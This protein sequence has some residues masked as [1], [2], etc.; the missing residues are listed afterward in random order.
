MERRSKCSA[1]RLLAVRLALPL[2]LCATFPLATPQLSSSEWLTRTL[3]GHP[4]A[5]EMRDGPGA[6]A[7]F[8]RP[9]SLVVQDSLV[10]IADAGGNAVRR[11]DLNTNLVTT[12]AGSAP[13]GFLDAPGAAARFNLPAAVALASDGGT[14]FIVDCNNHAVRTVHLPTGNVTTLVGSGE[15]FV[16]GGAG[17]A[18]FSFPRSIAV[19]QSGTTAYLS[20]TG[21]HAIREITL[22]QVVTAAGSVSWRVGTVRTLTGGN[23]PGFLD[24]AVGGGV[25]FGAARFESPQALTTHG[26]VNLIVADTGNAKVRVIDVVNR[27]VGT[28]DVLP[29]GAAPLGVSAAANGARLVVSTNSSLIVDVALVLVPLPP[30]DARQELWGVASWRVLV[31]SVGEAGFR[32]GNASFAR[33]SASSGI[34]L[35]AS[36]SALLADAGNRAVRVIEEVAS[37]AFQSPECHAGG[38]GCQSLGNCSC[39]SFFAAKCEDGCCPCPR[40]SYCGC[41]SACSG[42]PVPCPSGKTSPPEP[43]SRI[44]KPE[45]VNREP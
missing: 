34:A 15:G 30:G 42:I 33:L 4:D 19:S 37:A 31:G 43:E 18:S 5:V 16:N 29:S 22:V 39:G 1:A 6:T 32:D 12:V 28:W 44:S 27:T 11:L 41:F 45:S 23:G 17:S 35:S 25:A 3:A 2:L 21:N 24:A 8:I 14:L 9:A 36:G 40:G 26:A 10:W 13:A 7:T 38:C 20:D